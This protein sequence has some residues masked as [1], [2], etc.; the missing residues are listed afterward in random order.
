MS[1]P[2]HAEKAVKN[3]TAEEATAELARLSDEIAQHDIA[4]HQ[5]DAPTIT[6]AEYDRLRRRVRLIEE[7]YPNLIRK[8]SPSQKVGAPPSNRFRKVR[9]ATKMFSL[10]N[11]FDD[12]TV[13]DFDKRVR[14]F[15]GLDKND[16]VSYVA[17]PK[18]DGL[19]ATLR[20][21]KGRFVLG[22]TRGDGNEGED[23]TRNLETLDDIPKS[24]KN[25]PDV[26]EIR[27]E[28][29]MSKSSFL[30]LNESRVAKGEDV[31]A[32][33]RNAAAGSLRQ[34]DVSVTRSRPLRFFPYSWGYCSEALGQTQWGVLKR[35][36]DWG[37]VVNEQMKQCASVHELIKHYHKI[38]N[39]R[40]ELPYD[41]D[42]V[43][44]KVNRLDWQER[45]GFTAKDPRWAIAHKF[46]AEQATTVL[47]EIDIQVGRTGALTP[48][49]KLEP[50]TVGGVVVSNATLHN[51]DEI[52]R[53]DI[54][55]GDT[56]VIQRAGDVIP[57][58][59]EVVTEKR[60][61]DSKPYVYP[62]TCPACGSDAVRET[63]EKGR[64]DVVRRCTG[65]LICPAQAVERLKHFVSRAALD[66][67]GL[68]AKQVEAFYHDGLIKEPADIFTLNQH[69]DALLKKEGYGETSLRNLYAGIDQRRTA[70]LDRF[71][72]A[73][74]IRHIGGTTAGL[75]ARTFL[76]FDKFRAVAEKVAAG[77]EAAKE[78]M[79][80][81]DGVG[82]TVIEALA[83]FFGEQHNID[84]LDRLLEHVTTTEAEAPSSDSPVAGKTVVFTGKL[85]RM[86]RDEAKARAT[87]LGAKVAG[88]VSA[89]TD[90]LVAGP[91]AGSKLKKAED[92]KVRTMT[93]EEWLAL[94]GG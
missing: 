73:L 21:E 70:D 7:R 45:L 69:R 40:S 4:Y 25:A 62:T 80:S 75:F 88:S 87:S 2:D 74:G 86:T 66:I 28:V 13:Y 39:N 84:A 17:E 15:L 41:I 57:Q 12:K 31:F 78:E 19:S 6:D 72:F 34:L 71:I 93:E 94:I 43:V 52:E 36:E 85:E 47:R 81:I 14:K 79:A 60:P 37:F 49:A 11:A 32:N 5:K 89:K 82:P 27:G 56:V 8:D 76:T 10:D 38:E 26:V 35:F 91:G 53:K 61:K 3:L 1:E 77:D 44:Y 90:I 20:Y 51:E 29:Y 63:D 55:E 48:V 58:V 42:G 50:V 30:A 92:L 59:V 18:I 65:G 46:P 68:G 67:D 83:D 16:T 64:A 23:V 24:I 33:P 54:R 22:A 9:H